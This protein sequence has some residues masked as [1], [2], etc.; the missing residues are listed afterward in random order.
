MKGNFF[1][2]AT[3]IKEE[4]RVVAQVDRKFFSKMNLLGSRQNYL[5]TMAANVDMAMMV[6]ICVCL[7]EKVNQR[8]ADIN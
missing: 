1:N 3:E 8:S 4:E 6:A 2:T 7:D 5:V